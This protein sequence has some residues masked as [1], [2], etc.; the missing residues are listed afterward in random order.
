MKTQMKFQKILTLI[1]LIVA[2]LAVVL[3]L[4]FSSGVFTAAKQYSWKMADE[5]PFGADAIYVYANQ[6]NNTLL[7]MAIVL[8]VTTVLLYLMGCNKRRKYYITNY[9]AIGIFAVYALV[10]GI[11]LLVFCANCITL[12]NQIDFEAWKAHESI[13]DPETGYPKYTQYY[14]D[15]CATVYLGIVLFVVLLVNI[16]AWALN[17]VW[18]IKLMKGEKALLE[19]GAVE[20]QAE[21]EVA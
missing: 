12:Y 17:L 18:K 14:N 13:L 10:F 9:I 2:A 5:D 3:A 11:I 16:A 6:I 1:T 19:Q 8:L 20:N 15:N 7:I 4:S 21:L